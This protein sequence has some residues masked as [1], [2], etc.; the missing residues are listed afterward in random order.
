M[1]SSLAIYPDGFGRVQ[2]MNWTKDVVQDGVQTQESI[3]KQS[4]TWGRQWQFDQPCA[5]RVRCV[6]GLVGRFAV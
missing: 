3:D 1:G 6:R 5:N 2:E 4:Y